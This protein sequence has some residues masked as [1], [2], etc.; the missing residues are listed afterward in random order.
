MKRLLL[1]LIM[2]ISSIAFVSCGHDEHT[3][4]EW[5][6]TREPTCSTVGEKVRRCECG[7]AETENI[8]TKEH[9]ISEIAPVEPTCTTYGYTA[10]T[11][12]SSCGTYIEQPIQIAPAH[13]YSPSVATPP[14]CSAKGVN[15]F[16]CSGCAATYTEEVEPLGHDI[17]NATCTSP[18]SCSVCN[19]TEGVP[20]GHTTTLGICK[21]CGE[22]AQPT[23]VIN[24]LP[25]HT[26][27]EITGYKTVMTITDIRYRFMPTMLTITYSG[28][29]SEDS[30][31]LTDGK[32]FC[33]F[34]YKLYDPDGNVI[35]A[36]RASVSEL[37]VGDKFKDRTIVIE[38]LEELKDY[39][40]LEITDYQ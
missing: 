13:T 24:D 29:K 11:L 5:E 10:G 27:V 2:F 17:Q 37:S 15:L 22:Y 21:S 9:T 12:C 23:I 35:A 6:T 34:S 31:E 40:I 3:Y 28:M 33:G 20:L 8:P 25:I 16:T 4:G 32:Y 36:G 7:I 26:N 14:T 19:F 18:K 30:G 38:N 1:L 39:Y